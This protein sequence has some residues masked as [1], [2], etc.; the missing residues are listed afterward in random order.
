M[1]LYIVIGIMGAVIVLVVVCSVLVWR[2]KSK[3]TENELFNY[4]K[5]IEDMELDFVNTTREG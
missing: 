5:K 4:Q 2:L 3:Q 1:T